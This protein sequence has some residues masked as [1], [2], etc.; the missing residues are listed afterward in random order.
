MNLYPLTKDVVQSIFR[1]YFL[2]GHGLNTTL[3]KDLEYV[4][5]PVSETGLDFGKSLSRLDL[6]YNGKH[7]KLMR[8]HHCRTV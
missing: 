4:P 2:C 6:V 8:L 3:W 1:R 5:N 7:R